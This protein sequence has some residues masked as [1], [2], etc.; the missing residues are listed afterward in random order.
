MEQNTQEEYI[1]IVQILKFLLQ[2]WWIILISALL[3]AALLLGYTVG[4]VTPMYKSSVLFYVNNTSVSLGGTS[5]SISSGELSAAKTLV[6]TYCVILKT[7]LTLEEVSDNIAK[8]GLDYSYSDLGGMISYEAVNETEIFKVTVNSASPSDSCT[9]ANTIAQVLPKKISDVVEG[10]SVRV[11]DYAVVPTM[12][13]SP[14]YSKNT[15]LGFLGGAVLA[16]VILVIIYLVNDTITSEDWLITTY[17]EDIPLLST[18]PDA[19]AD[20]SARYSRYK[21][22]KYGYNSKYGYKN[23]YAKTKK[24]ST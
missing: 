4:F 20:N 2:K 8:S 24:E 1:D 22:S 7:R 13:S 5:L 16:A 10:S 11:V 15:M 6:D 17:K 3:C 21:Y 23:Y 19:N 9:I 18:I 14:N 12:R